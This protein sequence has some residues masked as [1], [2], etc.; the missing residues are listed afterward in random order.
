MRIV[1]GVEWTD[2]SFSAVRETL[3]LYAPEE[4]TLVHAVDLGILDYP[5][6]APAMADS[7]HRDM[8]EAMIAAGRQLLDKTSD[9]VP[10][11]VGSVKRL[12]EIG[13]PA[14]VILETVQS[15]HADLVVLGARGRGRVAELILG[16]VSH[17]VLAKTSCP[18]LLVKGPF[19]PVRRILVAAESE[20]DGRRLRT[21]LLAHP[22]NHRVEASLITVLPTPYLSDPAAVASYAQWGEEAKQSVQEMA[23]DLA[24]G[25]S[26]PHYAAKGEAL[27]GDPVEVIVQEAAKHDLLVVGSHGRK[28]LERLVLG[29]VSHALTHGAEC[30]VLIVR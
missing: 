15:A 13:A 2:Q 18:A 30:P 7:V 29:S 8:R 16:S 9:L 17:R 4:L 20:E 26:G 19:R 10:A 14:Q 25:L 1:V 11:S 21:W 5:Q 23:E 22:F 3:Q 27:T 6:F 12:C 28:G 24:K